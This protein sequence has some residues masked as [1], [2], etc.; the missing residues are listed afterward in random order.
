MKRKLAFRKPK[1]DFTSI[2]RL[3]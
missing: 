1:T 3:P 2:L